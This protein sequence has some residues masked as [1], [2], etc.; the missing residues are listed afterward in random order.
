MDKK[1]EVLKEQ[2]KQS[3]TEAWSDVDH[4]TE[5]GNVGIPSEEA[6]ERQKEWAETNEL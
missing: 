3:D 1:M 4:V 6:V 2:I 5:D